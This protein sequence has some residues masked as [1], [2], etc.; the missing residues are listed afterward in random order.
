MSTLRE[1]PY[2][3][4]GIQRPLGSSFPQEVDGLVAGPGKSTLTYTVQFSFSAGR[5]TWWN[6]PG[7]LWEGHV[8]QR[9]RSSQFQGIHQWIGKLGVSQGRLCHRDKVRDKVRDTIHKLRSFQTLGFYI[10]VL[11]ACGWG[12]QLTAKKSN[13]GDTWV[14]CA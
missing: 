5:P 2:Y 6:Y 13:K 7:D 14:A 4:S 11:V 3:L 10:L 12:D 8:A 9:G 1:V